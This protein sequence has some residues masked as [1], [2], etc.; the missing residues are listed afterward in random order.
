MC[1]AK[2]YISPTELYVQLYTG[3][4]TWVSCM[5]LR[6][7][8]SNTNSLHIPTSPS[9]FF[10]FVIPLIFCGRDI[11]V[12]DTVNSFFQTRNLEISLHSLCAFGLHPWTSLSS[13]VTL[14]SAHGFIHH[15][16]SDNSQIYISSPEI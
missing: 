12:S 6:L 11:S 8:V 15:L 5:Q 1:F 2:P 3:S 4:F 9:L 7:N 14:I 13:R 10:F 16:Y